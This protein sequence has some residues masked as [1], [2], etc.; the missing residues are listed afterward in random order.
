MLMII[1]Y[2]LSC[3]QP[4]MLRHFEEIKESTFVFIDSLC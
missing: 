3:Q 1:V 4:V 2:G